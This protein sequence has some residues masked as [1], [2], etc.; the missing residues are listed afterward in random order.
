M[1]GLLLT[2]MLAAVQQ[3]PEL[4]PHPNVVFARGHLNG[5]SMQATNVVDGGPSGP[6]ISRMLCQVEREGVSVTTWRQGNVSF[7]FGGTVVRGGRG[8]RLPHPTLR[9][10]VVDGVSYE[11]E[12]RAS[13]ELTDRYTDVAYPASQIVHSPSGF[14]SLAVRRQDSDL[15]LNLFDIGNELIA[16]QRLRVGFRAAE[17]DPMLWIDVPMTGLPE[18][19]NWCQAAMTSPNALRLRPS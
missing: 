10:L 16:A 13:D 7:S 3:L 2:A 6:T 14:Y 12:R 9:A 11:V 18:A 5:W 19:L 1:P 4:V 8:Q 15:W 17:A